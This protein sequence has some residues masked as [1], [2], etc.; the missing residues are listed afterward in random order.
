LF[1]IPDFSLLRSA[2]VT[3]VNI[4]EFF[5]S[6]EY[7]HYIAPDE[8]ILV[9][10][11]ADQEDSLLWQV[12]TNFYFRLAAARFTLTPPEFAAWPVLSTL[13]G[14]DE[15]IDFA[16]EFKAFLG[17]NQVKAVIVDSHVARPWIRLLAE[18]GMSP[19]A[20]DGV[21]FYRVP[22][23][24]LSSMRD[25]TA[26]EMAKRQAKLA[27]AT[28][29]RAANQYVARS[30]PLVKLD[31]REVQRQNLLSTPGNVISSPLKEGNWWGNLWLG[32][33]GDSRVAVGIVGDYDDLA[34]LVDEYRSDA[35]DVFFPYPM[36]LCD[37]SKEGTG[38]LLIIFT[39]EGLR[40]A[41]T[42]IT[43]AGM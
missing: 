41:M 18:A 39:P 34:P 27:F 29:V 26:H 6:A 1:V 10:P 12:R 24:V 23:I 40:R 5:N 8:N 3:S 21:L 22:T 15:I 38:Q 30:L 42:K 28:L 16:E 33:W 31:P 4:P 2:A 9:L 36:R 13:S 35:A 17:A 20:V 19:L 25:L 32:G 11:F 37:G 14:G 43:D 7:Q